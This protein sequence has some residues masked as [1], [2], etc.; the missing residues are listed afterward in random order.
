MRR[1]DGWANRKHMRASGCVIH[2]AQ[3]LSGFNVDEE[4]N[5]LRVDKFPDLYFIVENVFDIVVFLTVLKAI[6]LS[7]VLKGGSG[8]TSKGGSGST[9]KEIYEEY[10]NKMREQFK[11]LGWQFLYSVTVS[12]FALWFFAMQPL[13]LSA[14]SGT[15]T[16]A[17][18]GCWPCVMV[19]HAPFCRSW[20]L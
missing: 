12:F 1:I 3:S 15:C 10:A 20:L 6:E 19:L 8:S 13:P 18:P 9:P 11:D 5:I 14:N 7:S 2:I 16:E 4:E 17:L